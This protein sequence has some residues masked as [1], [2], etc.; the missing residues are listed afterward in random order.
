[1]RI[2]MSSKSKEDK[3]VTVTELLDEIVQAF[4]VD[5]CKY[6]DICESEKND[7]DEAEQMLYE[8]YCENCPMNKI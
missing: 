1:M 5:Y 3:K 7:P 2:E 4:C 6:P 8:K